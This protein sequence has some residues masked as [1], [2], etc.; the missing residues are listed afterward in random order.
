MPMSDALGSVV[1]GQA[2]FQTES[3]SLVLGD[4]LGMLALLP[5]ESIDCV[6]ADPPYNLSGGGITCHAGRMVPVD[7]GEWDRPSGVSEDH[8][9]ALKWLAECQ[10]LLAPNGTLW[11]SGTS[12]NI[13]SVGYALQELGYRILNDIVWFKSNAPPNLSC[14]Y[15]THSHEIVLWAAKSRRSKHVFHY[16][17]M[18]EINAG[19]QMRSVW[20]MTGPRQAEKQYG[21]HPTQKPLALLDR[22]ISASTQPGD[23][24]LDPFVGSGT[25]C[26]SALRLGRP[27]IGIDASPEY[28]E[29]ARCRLVDAAAELAARLPLA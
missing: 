20:Q 7:K 1:A 27:S 17:L 2:W 26:V 18:R 22:I 13:Y 8:E 11:V 23:V 15:F 9:F 21:K 16:D 12:H 19:K 29:I 3:A 5:D 14:R 24:V 4:V 10:R 6:F 28:L 25:T